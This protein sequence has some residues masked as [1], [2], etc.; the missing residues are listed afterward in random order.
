LALLEYLCANWLATNTEFARSTLKQLGASDIDFRH[1]DAWRPRVRDLLESTGHLNAAVKITRALAVD[2][3]LDDILTVVSVLSGDCKKQ[4]ELRTCI[5]R[6]FRTVHDD[7]AHLESVLMDQEADLK[8][9]LEDVQRRRSEEDVRYQ[10]E[11]K[12][13]VEELAK[14]SKRRDKL[15]GDRNVREETLRESKKHLAAAQAKL[16][17]ASKSMQ[18]WKTKYSR[19]DTAIANAN[20]K[21]E[22]SKQQRDSAFRVVDEE[23]K[24]LEND[25][26]DIA[27]RLK[28][29][30]ARLEAATAAAEH[31]ASEAG[32]GGHESERAAPHELQDYLAFVGRRGFRPTPVTLD[33][34]RMFLCGEIPAR[35]PSFSRKNWMSNPGAAVAYYA[36][37]AVHG[38]P[39]WNDEVLGTYA[40]ARSLQ[41]A[42]EAQTADVR[43]ELLV[44]GLHHVERMADGQLAEQ[45]LAR[46]IQMLPEEDV[47]SKPKLGIAECVAALQ[48]RLA[49]A[50]SGRRL[51]CVQARLAVANGRALRRLY[52][53]VSPRGRVPLKK[54]LVTQ[55]KGIGL[56][57]KDPTHEILDVVATHL[58]DVIG[59]LTNF[60]ASW[61]DSAT[62]GTE[63][64]RERQGLLA[65]TSRL[66]RPFFTSMDSRLAHF[67]ELLGHQLTQVM[68]SETLEEYDVFRGLLL[69]YCARECKEPEWVSSCY[70]F[71]IVIALARV[72]LRADDAVRQRRAEISI[73][74]EK[75]Q[76]PLGTV[77]RDLPVSIALKNSG[78]APATQVQ[79]EVEVDIP[80]VTVRPGNDVISK[81]GPRRRVL[82]SV[83][84]DVVRPKAAG[85]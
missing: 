37:L 68:A 42:E 81:I 41:D 69:Q 9:R 1:G 32:V 57:E 73:A 6:E 21:L 82:R 17:E 34:L 28:T 23:R 5:E 25:L 70:L 63:V 61:G 66:R 44:G 16:E 22:E 19:V 79:V 52:D 27:G 39:A 80:E 53:E 3:P 62:L 10:R 74:L 55:V 58:E 7:P 12:P 54:A 47:S 51:G 13:I 65:D 72:A 76:H 78:A 40:L 30:K 48:E 4:A 38:K 26:S 45:L 20:R 35:R 24:L 83:A 14:L 84:M 18:D 85:P 77:R 50:T 64:R 59:R 15:E 31:K 43:V 67:T 29:T 71:P 11:S 60:G 56:N 33:I 46:L 2:Y 8:G 49:V 75:Q 36:H